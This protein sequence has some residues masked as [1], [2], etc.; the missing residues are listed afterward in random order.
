LRSGI[1]FAPLLVAACST[2]AAE[3]PTPPAHDETP[4]YACKSDGLDTFVG[5]DGTPEVGK[6]VLAKSGAKSLR[7]LKPG[8]AVTMEFRSERVNI[9]VD[10]NNKIARVNCG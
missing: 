1:A 6:E 10:A 3:E 5:R 4:G 9:A 8:M 7:W 2:V